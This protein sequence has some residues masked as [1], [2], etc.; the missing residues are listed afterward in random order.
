MKKNL[1][2]TLII[3]GVLILVSGIYF[4]F[5]DN[6]IKSETTELLKNTSMII[7]EGTLTNTGCTV[8][9]TDTE[10]EEVHIYGDSF[11]LE[12]KKDNKWQKLKPIIED[13]AFNLVGYHV[14]ENNELEQD[15]KWEW[16]YGNLE[17]GEYRLVKNAAIKYKDNYL[18]NGV[19]YAEF[20]INTEEVKLGLI[21]NELT[22]TISI[23]NS[24]E[25]QFILN[26][27]NKYEYTNETCDGEA[28]FNLIV[29]DTT[30]GLEV[31]EKEVHITAKGREI[32]LNKEDSIK[33]I[34]IIN[35]YVP[36]NF[37]PIISCLKNELGGLIANLT[38]FKEEDISY[39]IKVDK[40]KLDYSYMQINGN[41][42][43]YLIVKSSDNS[44][45]ND[46]TELLKSKYSKLSNKSFEDYELYVY[47]GQTDI[48]NSANLAKCKID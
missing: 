13:Y 14:N 17:P 6:N 44:I 26:L 11:S 10:K 31:Y 46:I 38:E 39:L 2:I 22:N 41:G 20:T 21:T 47:N 48:I 43:F 33:V 24:D 42:D 5:N 19:V 7:K 9:I 16:L 32:V 35:K 37:K 1:K 36:D 34:N 3:L 4:I 23:N 27:F 28:S 30:Y 12:I 29:S 25:V 45:I 40:S 8:I 18:G 15:I